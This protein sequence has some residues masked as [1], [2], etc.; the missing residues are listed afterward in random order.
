[1]IAAARSAAAAPLSC[2]AGAP[3]F[4][5]RTR[6]LASWTH[7]RSP[8]GGPA[9]G[10]AE[11]VLRRAPG[12]SLERAVLTVLWDDGGWLPPGEVHARMDRGRP[13]GLATVATVLV[14]LWR[15]GR[16]ERKKTGRAF[17]YRAVQTREQFVA[18]R[19]DEMLA[20]AADRPAALAAFAAGLSEEDRAE[21]RRRLGG[22][23]RA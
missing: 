10:A 23:G 13:V 18:Q 9:A 11:P 19:M 15:K 3:G 8:G 12:G 7:D 4:R 16:L 20:V 22:G 17:A 14:R 1:V 6:L 5:R 21:L 2:H